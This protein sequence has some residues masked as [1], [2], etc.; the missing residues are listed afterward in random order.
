MCMHFSMLAHKQRE[1]QVSKSCHMA[2]LLT[3]IKNYK[4]SINTT[5]GETSRR[6]QHGHK[7]FLSISCIYVHHIINQAIHGKMLHFDK[8]C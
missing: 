1:T 6:N 7:K 5:R 2:M 3:N 4:Q 8:R